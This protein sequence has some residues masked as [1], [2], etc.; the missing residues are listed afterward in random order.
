M[1]TGHASPIVSIVTPNLNQA[2]FLESTIHSVLQQ[3]YPHLEYLILDGGS[4]DGSVDVIQRYANRLAY[5]VSES[6]GGQADAINRGWRRAQG[7]I[8]A[9]L[10]ADDLYL[11]GTV[12]RAVECFRQSPHVD[13]VYGALQIVDEQ[14][15]PNGGPVEIPDVSLA[16]LLRSPLPQ[17]TLF[18]RRTVTERIGLFDQTFQYV[19]DWDF[20][21]RAMVAG[22]RMAR[23]P[24]PPLAAFRSWEGQKTA[25]AFTS[26]VEEQLRMRDQLLANPNLPTQFANLVKFSK[27]WAFLWPAYQCYLRGQM[28]LAR[29]FLHEA[30]TVHHRM[31]IHPAFVGLYT[32]TLMGRRL[33]QGLRGLKVHLLKRRLT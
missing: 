6:D 26:H 20:C 13:M 33:S 9:Y 8:L 15:R 10:N 19:F 5:W 17:P 27:A 3:D 31:A 11:P 29:R 12:R 4:T 24:G 30:L 32:R 16:W 1:P 28:P 2:R 18:V 14:G 7:E 21:L 25:N 22:V 23:V